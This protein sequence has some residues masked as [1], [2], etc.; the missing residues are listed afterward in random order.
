MI[1]AAR[2]QQ[3]LKEEN[4]YKVILEV[5]KAKSTADLLRGEKMKP[6]LYSLLLGAV[7]S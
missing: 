4:I 3:A 6:V 1:A 7:L 2:K 5:Y